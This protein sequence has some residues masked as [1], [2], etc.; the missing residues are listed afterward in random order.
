M[1]ARLNRG[2]CTLSDADSTRS[3]ELRLL[4]SGSG[5]GGWWLISTRPAASS[6]S[7]ASQ[8]IGPVMEWKGS[9]QG[10]QP[11]TLWNYAVWAQDRCERVVG[12]PRP[13]HLW[14]GTHAQA[15][16]FQN[17]NSRKKFA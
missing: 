10:R 11:T 12:P 4:S 3:I 6:D 5:P 1:V 16:C 17:W 7:S 2:S 9:A 14:T 8:R 13:N 15:G